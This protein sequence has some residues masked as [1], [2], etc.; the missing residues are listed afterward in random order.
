MDFPT[1]LMEQTGWHSNE[2]TA[3]CSTI[4]FNCISVILAVRIQ[5]ILYR[6]TRCIC[7]AARRLSG[8]WPAASKKLDDWNYFYEW[9]HKLTWLN[10]LIP[11]WNIHI[12]EDLFMHE[13]ETGK[14]KPWV[15]PL[16]LICWTAEII[17]VLW[18]VYY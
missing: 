7:N 12:T 15:L 8:S 10:I 11:Y 1:T 4:R 6:F 16:E 2:Y 9:S 5:S 18:L 3:A 14:W 13:K 17:A